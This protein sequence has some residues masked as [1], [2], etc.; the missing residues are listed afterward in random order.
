LASDVRPRLRDLGVE[1]GDYPTGPHNAITD[2]PGVLVGHQT[3]IRDEPS[4]VRT[5]VTVVMPRDGAIWDDYAYCAIDHLNG[6]GEMTGAF[7]VMESGLLGSPIAI[8]NT[9]QVGMVRD[10]VARYG[11][12]EGHDRSFIL[13]V[14][15]ET[16]DG[17]LSDAES[18]PLTPADVYS[19]IRSASSGRVEEGTVGGGTG[20]I[21]HE[22]KGGIGTSSRRVSTGE[23]D[24]T[25]AALVQANYGNRSDLTIDGIRVGKA[26]GFDEVPSAW[27]GGREGEDGS[28]IVVIAT[29]APLVA[30]QCRRLARRAS[31][32]LARA[33]G[34]GHDSSGD[35]FV[36]FA[37][38]NHLPASSKVREIR[39]LD[40]T[41]MTPLLRAAAD[42]VEES[43][44]NALLAAKTIEG[45]LGRVAH[46]IPIDR[47]RQLVAHRP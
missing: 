38:G 20:M 43:I 24:V 3:V 45:R 7:W 9:H 4:V 46:A 31:V 32:G 47:V 35:I 17:H 14:V 2:V 29:D 25:V 30:D 12:E 44:V 5:G 27:E 36:A 15:A 40:H 34:Y 21:C 8:T 23:L 16:Y 39:S 6:D 19:A 13:P 41:V 26:I 28:I 42:V 10:S 33:G 18:F 37:T 11:L 1:I 22:F